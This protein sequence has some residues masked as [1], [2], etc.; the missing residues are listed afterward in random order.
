[1]ID[2]E[3]KNNDKLKVCKVCNNPEIQQIKC[4]RGGVNGN[5]FSFMIYM[6]FECKVAGRPQIVE[7]K[8]I[9]EH[10][11]HEPAL[12]RLENT[13]NLLDEA[14]EEVERLNKRIARYQK[15]DEAR[16]EKLRAS[17]QPTQEQIIE[18]D[19]ATAASIYEDFGR[20]EW[21]SSV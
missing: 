1:M 11:T 13:N 15:A 7:S 2:M 14:L 6:C 3:N 4:G 20:D 16:D 17:L 9:T 19:T 12:C 18:A 21:P 10:R 5:R 8:Y